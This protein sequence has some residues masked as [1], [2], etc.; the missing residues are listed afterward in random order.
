MAGRRPGTAPRDAIGWLVIVAVMGWV[1]ARAV[2][3][4]WRVRRVTVG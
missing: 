4:S 2:V 1:T 3:A